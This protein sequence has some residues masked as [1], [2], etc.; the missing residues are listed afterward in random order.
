MLV[1]SWVSWISRNCFE[2]SRVDVHMRFARLRSWCDLG[3][4]W[5]GYRIRTTGAAVM[6]W[7]FM[8]IASVSS[9]SHQNGRH[10]Q[11]VQVICAYI[12][13]S[14]PRG[15]G[16]EGGSYGQVGIRRWVVDGGGGGGLEFWE[17]GTCKEK[18]STFR[19]FCYHLS[20]VPPVV[21][22]R[23]HLWI[24]SKH[25]SKAYSAG[26]GLNPCACILF[27]KQTAYPQTKMQLDNQTSKMAWTYIAFGVFVVLFH[28]VQRDVYGGGGR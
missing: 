5:V 14:S 28:P 11:E 26:A 19:D 15:G 7:S 25:C 13:W 20:I 16:R 10:P 1:A 2:T 4:R 9:V 17:E 27:F 6:R 8:S 18:N 21:A 22:S 24:L 12:W 3:H 23:E